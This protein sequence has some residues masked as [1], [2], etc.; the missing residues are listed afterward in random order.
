MRQLGN[1]TNRQRAKN[2]KQEDSKTSLTSQF[3]TAHRLA[4]RA[5]TG[6]IFVKRIGLG[7]AIRYRPTEPPPSPCDENLVSV[8]NS[9]QTP[10][11]PGLGNEQ[12][13]VD[14][15]FNFRREYFCWTTVF[16]IRCTL[17]RASPILNFRTE[18]FR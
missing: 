17:Q 1:A 13:A 9:E 16:P 8:T 6:A 10:P 18:Q 12:T 3:Q 2:Y 4:A 5:K 15:D 7:C 14:E 11:Y